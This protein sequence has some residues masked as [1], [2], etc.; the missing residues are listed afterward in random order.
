VEELRVKGAKTKPQ[1][2]IGSQEIEG[3]LVLGMEVSIEETL[4]V[5]DCT[6]V[7]RA[8]GKKY[9]SEFLQVWGE[10]CFVSAR[11]IQFEAQVLGKGW[12]KLSFAD[13]DSA[14]WV[15]Q[16]NWHIGN[17]PI[18]LKKWTPM[19][20]AF[21]ERADEFPVWIR[22][23]GLPSFLW[24]EEVFKSIGNRLGVYLEADM[25]FLE[26]KDRTMARILALLLPS[27]GLAQKINLQY[28][29]YV[30]EQ[31]LDYEYLPFRCHRCHEYGHLA[32]DC[33]Q[34]RRRRHF[35]RTT[36]HRGNV[37]TLCQV[38]MENEIQETQGAEDMETEEIVKDPVGEA[39]PNREEAQ[40]TVIYPAVAVEEPDKEVEV[41]EEIVKED[42]ARQLQRENEEKGMCS[43]IPISSQI[44]C[45]CSFACYVSKLSYARK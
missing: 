40:E 38:P 25:T 22:A 31:I 14:E 5:A 4:A 8:R 27:R 34:L 16:R 37:Q 35:R 43:G 9:S 36:M 6:L 3:N 11:P 32:K 41:A 13:K 15:F 42:P 39:V 24:T 23:P 12:F 10:T 30:F 1:R 44:A 20:D 17:I 19:F 45:F 7:G 21:K 2:P 28:K 29:D 18:L 26:T 33:P